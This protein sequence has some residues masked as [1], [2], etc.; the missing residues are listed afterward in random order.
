MRMGIVEQ[1]R[2]SHPPMPVLLE[3]ED[4]LVQGPV[5]PGLY[6]ARGDRDTVP[7][8][9]E[10]VVDLLWFDA[11]TP[12]R[13]A[14]A[15]AGIREGDTLSAGSDGCFPGGVRRSEGRKAPSLIGPLFWIDSGNSFDPYRM[16]V[17]ARRRGLDPAR[18]L[19]AIRVARPFTAFQFRQ[20]LDKVPFA[21]RGACPVE[22]SEAGTPQPAGLWWTPLVII[23]D[24]TSLFYDPEISESDVNRAFQQFVPQLTELSRRAVVLSLVMDYQVPARRRQFLPEL[25]RNA[26]RIGPW[27]SAPFAAPYGGAA[28]MPLPAHG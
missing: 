22:K 9:L 21:A 14:P 26:R 2:H 5:Q 25:L 7:R 18:V 16:S 17:A 10:I 23:S 4:L 27:Y 8:L 3:L 12:F 15:V 13:D 1:V 11:L 20:M 28:S 19:R 24:L 6:A